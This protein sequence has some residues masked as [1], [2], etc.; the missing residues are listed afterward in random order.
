MKTLI[1]NIDRDNDFGRKAKV[2]SPIIGIEDNIKAANKL[3]QID[4]E[5]S[6]LNAIFSAISTYKSIKEKATISFE[7]NPDDTDENIHVV[8]IDKYRVLKLCILYGAN[9]SGKTNMLLAL[10]FL[11]NFIVYSSTS[12][13]PNEKNGFIPFLFDENSI[14]KPGLFFISFFINKGYLAVKI[15][16]SS[17]PHE[18]PISVMG[19]TPFFSSTAFSSFTCVSIVVAV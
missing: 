7:A 1:L 14:N 11:R 8:K 12:I 2:N 18:K 19:S 4:P 16:Q 15:K 10:D 17:A 3:G 9:A 5:D 13:R 6:D